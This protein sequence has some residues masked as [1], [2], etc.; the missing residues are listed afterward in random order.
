LVLN[1]ISYPLL[2]IGKDINHYFAHL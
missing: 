1:V 2:V